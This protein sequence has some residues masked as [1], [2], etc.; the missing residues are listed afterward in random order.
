MAVEIERK[1]LV[2]EATWRRDVNASH[3]IT[4]HLIARFETGKARIRMCDGTALL[5]FK[6]NRNGLSRSEYHL[7]LDPAEAANM[8][9]DFASSPALQKWRHEVDVDGL[10]WQVDEYLG[11]L[12]GLVTADVELPHEQHALVQPFWAGPEITHDRRYSSSTL[13]TLLQTGEAPLKALLAA[14]S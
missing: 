11:V 3:H 8:I 7:H 14:R 5:T 9:K 12:T 4:D 1:F 10:T 13:C 6:G 2:T